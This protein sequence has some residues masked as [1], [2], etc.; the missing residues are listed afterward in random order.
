MPSLGLRSL[1]RKHIQARVDTSVEI[2]DLRDA[3]THFAPRHWPMP[4]AAPFV[5]VVA[6][7]E[8]EGEAMDATGFDALACSI[9]DG[10]SRRGLLQGIVGTVAGLLAVGSHDS[11]QARKKRRRKRKKKHKKPGHLPCGPCENYDNGL[12]VPKPAGA[13]CRTGA[14]CLVNDSCAKVCTVSTECGGGCACGG[15]V[16]DG[17]FCV[18]FPI[19]VWSVLAHLREHGSASPGLPM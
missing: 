10:S 14:I 4:C 2:R 12:C 1:A 6:E 5:I 3:R 8:S 9:V 16:A 7:A 17:A 19:D 11:A 18:G 15:S 13:T